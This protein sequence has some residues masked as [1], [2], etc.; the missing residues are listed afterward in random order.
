M[1]Q[2]IGSSRVASMSLHRLGQLCLGQR[3]LDDALRWYREALAI[4]RRQA[5]SLGEC[6]VQHGLGDTHM[7]RGDHAEAAGCLEGALVTAE[8][9][10]HLHAA[11]QVRVSLAEVCIA[12]GL[13]G[14]ARNLLEEAL[15]VLEDHDHQAALTR[16][17]TA[18]ARLD[19]VNR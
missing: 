7:A 17:R 10:G 8:A 11:A 3:R 1:C 13:D 16:A 2:S 9:A 4:V 6:I 5:D 15:R 12:Q 14:R 19:G 18:L